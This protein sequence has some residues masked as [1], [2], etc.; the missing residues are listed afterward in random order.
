MATLDD[1]LLQ[2]P[3]IRAELTKVYE[4]AE[5]RTAQKW[6]KRLAKLRG[7]TIDTVLTS[8]FVGAT[9]SLVVFSGILFA[10]R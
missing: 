5:R 10:L 9:V 3:E 8:A 1:P 7:E 4:E 2:K 6:G